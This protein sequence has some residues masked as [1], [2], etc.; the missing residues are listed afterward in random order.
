MT[1]AEPP[2]PFQAA[3]R[4]FEAAAAIEIATNPVKL[5]EI[6][7]HDQDDCLCALTRRNRAAIVGDGGNGAAAG[8][9]FSD[10][11]KRKIG[12]VA[13]N[14]LDVVLGYFAVAEREQRQLFDFAAR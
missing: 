5:Q 6:A 3:Q 13:D 4:V 8:W 14:R 2:S 11:F 1:T 12:G 10:A 7:L 9:G